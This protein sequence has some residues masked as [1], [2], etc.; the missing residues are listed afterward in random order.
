MKSAFIVVLVCTISS[1][2]GQGYYP[3]GIGDL[4]Q[5]WE[6]PGQYWEVEVADDSLMPNDSTYM[7]L[8]AY[9][10]YGG[11]FFRQSGPLVLA[12]DPI[13]QEEKLL[14]D[15]SKTTGDTV[16][17]RYY[18]D[19]TL[20]VTI[21][22]DQMENH[23]GRIL[24]TWVFLEVSTTSTYYAS[25]QVAD[26]LGVM[27]V[28]AEGGFGYGLQGAI[29][30][31]VQYGV[32]QGASTEGGPRP[33]GFLLSNNYPN[34]LNPN[35]TIEYMPPQ[36]AFVKLRV[37]NIAGIEIATLVSATETSGIHRTKWNADGFPSGVYFYR[38]D[39]GSFSDIR[40]G[41]L[42]R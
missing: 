1:A 25:W 24:R 38:L 16:T 2:R 28:Q 10:G 19:D 40:K 9:G 29:I 23:F 30:N 6:V 12:Y 33:G 26:S 21:Y 3:L 27:S 37:F 20:V 41:V 17:I 35:T 8:T 13:R 32:I 14:F 36:A 5:Y 4:W 11:G 42:L 39:A 15:F 22:G 34:P 18:A 7:V 31:G